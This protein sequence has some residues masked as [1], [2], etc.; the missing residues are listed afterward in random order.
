MTADPIPFPTSPLKGEE[1]VTTPLSPV[2]TRLLARA[3]REWET[4]QFD[5]AEHSLASVLAL[6]P[7]NPKAVRMLGMVARSRGEYA[8]AV[9]CFR[10][11]LG[12]WPEDPFLHSG[13]GLALLSQGELEEATRHFRRACGLD[14]ESPVAWFNLGEALW[15]QALG[16]E[17]VA[18]LQHALELE[19]AHVEARLA[20][21]RTHAGM[22]RVEDAVA[23]FREVLR[24]DPDNADGWYGLSMI[25]AGFDAADAAYLQRAFARTDLPARMHYLLGFA[26]AKALEDQNDFARAFEVLG[27]ANASQ[28]ASMRVNWNA[29]EEH[30][31]MGAIQTTFANAVSVAP[32]TSLGRQAI[33]VTG[34]PRSGTTLVEQVLAAH[35]EVEGANEIKDMPWVINAESQRRRSAFPAWTPDATVEDW[36]RLGEEYLART[37]RWHAS[38]PRFTDKNLANWHSVGAVLAMLPAARVVI[39][40]RDPVETCLAC[41]RHCF[42]EEAGF[43]CDLDDIADYCADFLRLAHF[44]I[45][46]YPTRVF[47]LQYEALLADPEHVVRCVLDFCELP[48]DPSCLEFHKTSRVVLTPSAAQVR[49]PLRRDTARSARYGDKLDGLRKRLRDAGVQVA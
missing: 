15:R 22:G 43:A 46:K 37:A 34:M 27:E 10:Q 32:D 45:K 1:K 31:L 11:V 26:L 42:T 5:A 23:A 6:A 7:D 39:V 20:L 21:A 12:V 40:R 8:K 35:P 14:P 9:D 38:S 24:R 2:A 25:A 3:R 36:Q 41:Y 33:F 30:T 19:P 4:H 18:A 47:D 16:G 49:Q 48:F 13:L 28:R 29:A 44:W 17:A